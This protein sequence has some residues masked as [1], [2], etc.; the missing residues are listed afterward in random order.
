MKEIKMNVP[1][2]EKTPEEKCAAL[3][4]DLN[5]TW[6]PRDFEV[7]NSVD[8]SKLDFVLDDLKKAKTALLNFS[9]DHD[10]FGVEGEALSEA[11]HSEMHKL[12]IERQDLLQAIDHVVIPRTMVASERDGFLQFVRKYHSALDRMHGHLERKIYARF[13]IEHPD[14]E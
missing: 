12:R 9:R 2:A 4:K 8:D 5:E 7:E 11:S 13:G 10:L 1:P 3:V 6:N 14:D